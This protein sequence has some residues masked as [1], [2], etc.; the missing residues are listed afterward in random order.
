M[1]STNGIPNIITFGQAGDVITPGD[2]DGDGTSDIAVF[3][4]ADGDWYVL[5]SSD[6]TITG[7]NWGLA[8]DVPI[9]AAY[10]PQ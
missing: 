3:R 1:Q 9:P 5:K 10:L 4:P 6:T 2:Y 8:G 7:V